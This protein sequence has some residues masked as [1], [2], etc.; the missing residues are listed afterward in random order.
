V[1]RAL[2]L[3]LLASALLAAPAAAAPPL[4]VEILKRLSGPTPFPNACGGDTA[5]TRGSEAEP[6]I[7][8]DPRR[9]RH[10][11]GTW[12]QDRFFDQDGGA[13]TNLVARSRDGGRS[14]RVARLPR[15]SR[16][17]GGGD[18][19][20]SD[21]WVAIGPGGNALV[22]SLTFTVVPALSGR[23]GP[24]SLSSSRSADGGASFSPPVEIV[25]DGQYDDREAVTADPTRPGRAYV[26]WVRR[27]GVLGESGVEM[28]SRT[29]DGGRS[30]SAPRTIIE[31]KP[32][33][34]P[35][36]TLI[37][38]LPDGTLL[39][40][41]LEANLTPFLPESVPR[42]PWVVRASRS[43]DGGASWSE[44][45]E[46]GQIGRPGAPKDPDSGS[47][48]R[49][50]NVISATVAPGGAAYVAWNEIASESASRILIS[51]SRDGGRT[52]SAPA[53]VARPATQAFLPSVAVAGD[54]GVG[55][56][57]DDFR[58]D[59]R[60]DGQLT[61]EVRFA[62]SADRGAHWR[63]RRLAGPFDLLTAP[64]TS[65][66][67]V[68]GRFIGDYQG[69][70]GLPQGFGALFAVTKPRARFGPTDV[71]FARIET[72][73]L[74]LRLS[75]R[76]RRLRAGR[77]VRMR[78][79]VTTVRGARRV[80]VRRALVRFRGRRV[81]TNRRGRARLVVRPR[82]VGRSRV[83]ASRRGY[84][85]AAVRVR[86]TRPQLRG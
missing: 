66:T 28:F 69:L 29:T 3:A 84:K 25:D 81:R 31:P 50:F 2:V 47:Q 41:Y 10:L 6:H 77:R 59:R 75:V 70:T 63:Q 11:V 58:G 26:A 60:G 78:I 45:V 30:W 22:S 52:W 49:A 4:R 56:T 17:T 72:N 61:T 46:I 39:N 18:E 7:A 48:V 34:L 85:G 71:F 1:R 19:R 79:R 14:W 67:E 8:V 16:C 12:Q 15:V 36:P 27:L 5:R 74:R 53:A 9:P 83:R 80:P 24:T 42:V 62:H 40:L 23:A 51:R 37:Q 43:T 65:S 86:V 21:P 55:V 35:D 68:A 82:R 54:G 20:T 73:R 76:P 38:V 32:G 44:P 33:T 57:W 64:E 13:L